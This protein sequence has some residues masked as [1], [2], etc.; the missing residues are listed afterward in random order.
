M[1][2]I[3]FTLQLAGE[4]SGE[5]LQSISEASGRTDVAVLVEGAEVRIIGPA[6]PVVDA[7][8]AGAHV[9]R[10]DGAKIHCRVEVVGDTSAEAGEVAQDVA[11]RFQEG[12]AAAAGQ[13]ATRPMT[14]L[15]SLDPYESAQLLLSAISDAKATPGGGSAAALAGAAG[16]ALVAMVA[17]ITCRQDQY[18]DAHEEMGRIRDRALQLRDELHALVRSDAEAYRALLQA[19]NLPEGTE[20]QADA[21]RQ[22]FSDAARSATETPLEIMRRGL[23]IIELAARLSR[24]GAQVA[25][26]DATVAALLAGAAVRAAWSNVRVNLPAV[27]DL[28]M[29]AHLSGEAGTLARQAEETERHALRSGEIDER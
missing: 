19:Q 20:E 4:P 10:E 15:P 5:Q 13:P 16:A 24:R 29:R 22:A 28:E 9:G 26:T 2:L 21:R 8:V 1:R 18:A 14:A 3:A 7:A 27:R 6:D 23:T 17:G 12:L 11:T 25:A